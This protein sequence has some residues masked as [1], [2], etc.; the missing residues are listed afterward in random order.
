MQLISRNYIEGDY[1]RYIQPLTKDNMKELFEHNFGGWSDDVSKNKFFDVV[2]LGFVE[3]FFLNEQFV[4]Y[5]SFNVEVNN[6]ESILINDIH[7]IKEFQQ[8]GYGSQI[9]DF[10]IIKAHELKCN[11]L[12]LFVFENNSAIEF[13]K[14]RGFEEIEHLK[15]SNTSVMVRLL[16]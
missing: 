14:K 12:K 9:L 1:E 8:K 6:T 15:K 4:G 16:H 10:V 3:L 11:R 5:V 13:Y 2:S 7:I